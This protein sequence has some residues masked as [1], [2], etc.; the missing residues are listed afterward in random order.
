MYFRTSGIA[1]GGI[2]EESAIQKKVE[3]DY[4]SGPE[5]RE[6]DL[7]LLELGLILV[8]VAVQLLALDRSLEP[9]LAYTV[10]DRVDLCEVGVELSD[11][12]LLS[13]EGGG[14]SDEGESVWEE[15]LT[16]GEERQQQG[17]RRHGFA[18]GSRGTGQEQV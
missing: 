2:F 13:G 14:P 11:V 8:E 12:E 18:V 1:K 17:E 7:P 9:E 4:V 3:R 10:C 16:Q 6:G 5:P 15:G